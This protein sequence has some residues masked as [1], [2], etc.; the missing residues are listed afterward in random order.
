MVLRKAEARDSHL[1]LEK[2]QTTVL[3]Q[4][5]GIKPLEERA[6]YPT[7][8]SPILARTFPILLYP[9]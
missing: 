8:V 4:A 6:P 7:R 5:W 9:L 1:T 3:A 2:F